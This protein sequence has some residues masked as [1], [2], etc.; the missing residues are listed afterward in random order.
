MR[1]VFLIVVALLVLTLGGLEVIA[2]R[3]LPVADP[4]PNDAVST[5]WHWRSG[6]SRERLRGSSVDDGDKC[7][8]CSVPSS[9]DRFGS[10]L[11]A[12]AGEALRMATETSEKSMSNSYSKGTA[13][14]TGS[15][16]HLRRRDQRKA[17]RPLCRL[18]RHLN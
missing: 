9:C 8:E 1:V 5:S 10:R 11:I 14:I 18:E 6:Q 3:R 15:S 12:L 7:H 16:T 2:S 17:N 4:L 13:L